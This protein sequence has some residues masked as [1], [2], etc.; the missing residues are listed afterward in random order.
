[1]LHCMFVFGN[2]LAWP[3][4]VIIIRFCVPCKKSTVKCFKLQQCSCSC[5]KY[6]NMSFLLTS[7]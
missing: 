3:I 6:Y 4:L 7:I 1:M 5:N 2:R